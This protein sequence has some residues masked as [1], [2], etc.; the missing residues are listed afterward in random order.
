MTEVSLTTVLTRLDFPFI[1]TQIFCNK[2]LKRFRQLYFLLFQPMA[3]LRCAI[4]F[5]F[6]TVDGLSALSCGHTFHVYC[7]RKWLKVSSLHSKVHLRH[8]T[9]F[10]DAILA[11]I[12]LYRLNL[13][14]NLFIYCL[15]NSL[16]LISYFLYNR[17][18]FPGIPESNA[19]SSVQ[20]SLRKV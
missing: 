5:T 19:L 1:S 12:C 3:S 2:V 10:F 11:S 18:I 8:F 4:C 20:K 15:Y 17:L 13:S 7:I 9:I 14:F 16:S 6:A